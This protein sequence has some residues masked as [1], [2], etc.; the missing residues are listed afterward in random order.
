VAGGLQ[1][2]CGWRQPGGIASLSRLLTEY[3]EA[4]AY[5][6]LTVGRS[7]DDLGT[8]ALS[9]RDLKVIARCAPPGGALHRAVDPDGAGWTVGDYLTAA[10]ID[11]TN[12]AN[13]QRAGDKS[14]PRPEPIPRPGEQPRKR[15][16]GRNLTQAALEA[17]KAAVTHG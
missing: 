13:W 1:G 4:L 12:A 5:E 10:L 15:A 17:R 16:K 11:A 6:V 3:G 9:W 8:P 14:K 7:L 2:H